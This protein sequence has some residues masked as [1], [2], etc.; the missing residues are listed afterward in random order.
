MN[1]DVSVYVAMCADPFHAGHV[2]ILQAAA[3]LG[4]R[5]VVG[6]L[7]DDAIRSYKG[8]PAASWENRA[9]VLECVRG[10]D[11]VVPQHTLSYRDNLVRL[12]PM[13]VV[14]GS[15]WKTGT[16]S[17][18]REE[19]VRLLR[20]WGGQLVEPEYTPGISSTLIRNH[21]NAASERSSPG[22]TRTPS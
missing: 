2:N 9:L 3:R 11:A 21:A 19:V 13:F 14:H 1:T 22:G 10:V 6:L 18:A 5:V 17:H 20:Q 16:Q 4:G 7:T 8:E 15:D 12:R